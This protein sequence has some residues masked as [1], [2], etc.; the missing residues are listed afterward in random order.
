MKTTAPYAI[1]WK[2]I[3]IYYFIWIWF[4]YMIFHYFYVV[5][6]CCFVC[7]WRWHWKLSTC[8]RLC[9]LEC[10]Q[11]RFLWHFFPL[12]A[13][14]SDLF[15]LFLSCLYIVFASV[16]STCRWR[17]AAVSNSIKI[18]CKKS[19][20]NSTSWAPYF[21]M[22]SDF[23]QLDID[24]IT[25]SMKWK[26]TPTNFN[27]LINYISNPQSGVCFFTT[28]KRR[29]EW[30]TFERHVYRYFLMNTSVNSHTHVIFYRQS[31]FPMWSTFIYHHH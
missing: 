27:C 6:W 22:K 5:V 13:F 19:K 24:E 7:T 30:S 28:K 10:L 1:E 3:L 18:A 2:T 26:Y 8:I 20:M 14:L 29:I 25:S 4:S 9:S 17:M 12:F 11:R 16:C 21:P 23:S 31:I 15:F